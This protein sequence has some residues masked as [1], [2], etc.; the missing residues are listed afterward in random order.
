MEEEGIK[1]KSGRIFTE[2]PRRR[3]SRRKKRGGRR[4]RRGREDKE[5]QELHSRFLLLYINVLES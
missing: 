3:K 5:E 2:Q 4:E 1:E